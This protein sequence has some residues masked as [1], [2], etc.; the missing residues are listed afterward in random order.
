MHGMQHPQG[1]AGAPTLMHLLLLF[2]AV[3]RFLFVESVRGQEIDPRFPEMLLIPTPRSV[4][5]RV[6]RCAPEILSLSLPRALCLFPG[7]GCV[8]WGTTH[9]NAT[10]AQLKHGHDLRAQVSGSDS[11]GSD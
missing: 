8:V 3:L 4:R 10:R 7:G 5:Q 2:F 1:Q 9:S 6:M 11:E